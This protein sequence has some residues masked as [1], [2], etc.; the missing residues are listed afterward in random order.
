MALFSG[1]TSSQ[2]DDKSKAEG[3]SITTIHAAKGLEWAVVFVPG[4]CEGR[5]P[6][7]MTLGDPVCLQFHDVT[8]IEIRG[9]RR[10]WRKRS[11][12]Y[13]SP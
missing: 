2:Q 8:K 6:H 1:E 12:Y 3:V 7:S 10:K 13:L 4:V 5:I 11:G 9:F